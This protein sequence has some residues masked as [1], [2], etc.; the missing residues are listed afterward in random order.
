[1][2]MVPQEVL[3]TSVAFAPA[4]S[5]FSG[6][7]KV[8]GAFLAAAGAVWSQPSDPV[9]PVA[10]ADFLL[11]PPQPAATART[12]TSAAAKRVRLTRPPRLASS[13]WTR[14]RRAGR[15]PVRGRRCG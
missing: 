10:P 15:L 6:L 12:R 9:E 11:L 13:G 5:T 2:L 4:E 14:A 7:A 3:R 1:M 8:G